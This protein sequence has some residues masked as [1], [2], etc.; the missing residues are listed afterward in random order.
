MLNT[1]GY[2]QTE[3]ALQLGTLFKTE[4]ALNIGLIDKVVPQEEVLSAAQQEM[5]RWF[6]IPGRSIVNIEFLFYFYINFI[7][8]KRAESNVLSFSMKAL[9]PSEQLNHQAYILLF[10]P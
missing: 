7:L 8:S 3:M 2:R 6:K 1:V 5:Q 4:E 10:F 9:L